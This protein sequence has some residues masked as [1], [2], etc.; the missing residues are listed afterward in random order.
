M[1]LE[2]IPVDYRPPRK[3]V[4]RPNHDALKISDNNGQ[5]FKK[6]KHVR[7]EAASSTSA[8]IGLPIITKIISLLLWLSHAG[9]TRWPGSDRTAPMDSGTL[10]PVK[11]ILC[12]QDR[13]VQAKFVFTDWS[14]PSDNRD[15]A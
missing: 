9:I 1:H 3:H 13:P 8:T 10:F 6:S 7:C 4:K 12:R 5:M 2:L 14:G 11:R 15:P